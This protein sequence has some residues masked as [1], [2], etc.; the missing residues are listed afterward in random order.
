MMGQ[1]AEDTT[2][3][4]GES[5]VFMEALWNIAQTSDDAET[6]RIAV[7]ALTGTEAGQAYI[8]VHPMVL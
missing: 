5:Y 8:R 1:N 4:L 7:A 3:Q 6:V 2:S